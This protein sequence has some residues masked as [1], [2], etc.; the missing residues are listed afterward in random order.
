[1]KRI[2]HFEAFNKDINRNKSYRDSIM[3]FLSKDIVISWEPA[4]NNKFKY[5]I[6]DSDV[7]YEHNFKDKIE[8]I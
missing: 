1:M 5:L 3:Q 4:M 7:I 8:G 6:K 2:Y